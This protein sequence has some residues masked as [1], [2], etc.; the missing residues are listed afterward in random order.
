MSFGRRL[1]S[2]G[3]RGTKIRQFGFREECRR[4]SLCIGYR[5]S[6]C[7]PAFPDSLTAVSRNLSLGLQS[8]AWSRSHDSID[9][10][11]LPLCTSQYD[12]EAGT[13]RTLEPPNFYFIDP[14]SGNSETHTISVNKNHKTIVYY[15]TCMKNITRHE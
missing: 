1:E 3:V 15:K 10:R 11:G 9:S 5:R 12:H 6:D 14:P 2:V 13:A 8:S 4:G 7:A